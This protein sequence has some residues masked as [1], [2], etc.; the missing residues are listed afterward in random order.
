MN[1]TI[2][3]RKDRIEKRR[4]NI[5]TWWMR[6]NKLIPKWR[7]MCERAPFHQSS[8]LSKREGQERLC[9]DTGTCRLQ[10][11]GGVKVQWEFPISKP[12]FIP[13]NLFRRSCAR[14]PQTHGVARGMQNAAWSSKEFKGPVAWIW[15]GKRR[16]FMTPT[17]L[18]AV[19]VSASATL[20]RLA[21]ICSSK[22]EPSAGYN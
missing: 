8:F 13:Q 1:V 22:Q 4:I 14:C 2:R 6:E 20:C 21:C 17:A 3:E 18:L 11:R 19:G 10:P 16:R 12:P 5:T 9:L 7:E 15:A